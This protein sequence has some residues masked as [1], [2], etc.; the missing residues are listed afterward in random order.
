MDEGPQ[1]EYVRVAD[2]IE[3]RIGRGD[4]RYGSR[5]PGRERLAQA[6]GTSEMTARRALR[7]LERRGVVRVL[8]SSGAWVTWAGHI[9]GT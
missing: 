3:R 8:P 2:E 9:E 6:L 1:Y 7:E 5:L 4:W